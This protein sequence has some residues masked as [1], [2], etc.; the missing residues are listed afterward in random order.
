MSRWIKQLTHEDC[1]QSSVASLLNLPLSEVPEFHRHKIVEDFYD[2][3]ED[4]FRSKG[5]YLAMFSGQFHPE[6]YYLAS[7]P[8][9]R[10]YNHMVVMC[11]GK[12][13]HDPH[14]SNAGLLSVQC[15]WVPIP[16]DPSNFKY[17]K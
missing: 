3:V 5:Y 6:T 12:L 11:N 15:T 2:A 17:D 10:G 13:Y 1:A 9:A 7:G 4:Y 8:A 14:A 16:I